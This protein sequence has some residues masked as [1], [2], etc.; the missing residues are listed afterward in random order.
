MSR[1]DPTILVVD[2]DEG[3]LRA[4]ERALSSRGF[5]VLSASSATAALALA[6]EH[7]D[8]VVADLVM[9]GAQGDALVRKLRARQPKGC[10]RP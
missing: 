9:P 8:A 5:R 7:L 4:T 6:P 10:R 1:T 3:V 2:D